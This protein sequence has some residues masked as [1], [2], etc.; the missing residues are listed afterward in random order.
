MKVESFEV[1][2]YILLFC[3]TY[4]CYFDHMLSQSFLSGYYNQLAFAEVLHNRMEG[5]QQA[6]CSSICSYWL[7]LKCSKFG[8]S[9]ES[10]YLP[11]DS[12]FAVVQWK[13]IFCAVNSYVIVNYFCSPKKCYVSI[14][15]NHM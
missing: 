3:F 1:H 4:F 8:S 9:R 5:I 10:F 6:Y 12:Y 7:F 15:I 2:T 13:V 14:V 11:Y